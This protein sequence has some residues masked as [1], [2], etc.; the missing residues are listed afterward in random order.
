[1]QKMLTFRIFLKSFVALDLGL[2]K[3]EGE[4]KYP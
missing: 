1:M 2:F 3:S 4:K